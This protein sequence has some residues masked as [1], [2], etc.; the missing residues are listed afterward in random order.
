MGSIAVSSDL[1]IAWFAAE[2]NRGLLRI[3]GYVV[4]AAFCNSKSAPNT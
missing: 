2:M 4:Q 3:A 1:D